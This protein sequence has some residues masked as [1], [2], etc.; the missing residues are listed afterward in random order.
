M[1]CLK[2]VL[3]GKGCDPFFWK[4]LFGWP[5]GLGSTQSSTLSLNSCSNFRMYFKG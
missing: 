4:E 5:Y 1:F 2:Q 3:A